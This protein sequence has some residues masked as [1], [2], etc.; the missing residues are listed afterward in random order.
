MT[1]PEL[2]RMFLHEALRP[3]QVQLLKE[4]GVTFYKLAGTI[5]INTA[6]CPE[7]TI[8]LRKLQEAQQ[9]LYLAVLKSEIDQDQAVK[10]VQQNG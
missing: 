6:E 3:E 9:Y 7:T 2:K 1:K 4:F 5:V 10:I 8:A